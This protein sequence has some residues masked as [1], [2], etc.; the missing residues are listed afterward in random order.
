M[1][2]R[3][4]WLLLL[5]WALWGCDEATRSVVKAQWPAHTRTAQAQAGAMRATL[6]GA[7]TD[8]RWEDA[9]VLLQA[10]LSLEDPDAQAQRHLLPHITQHRDIRRRLERAGSIAALRLWPL[11]DAEVA[12]LRAMPLTDAERA[13]LDALPSASP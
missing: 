6:Q 1:S 7:L 9:E 10:L 11:L 12:A 2:Q 13:I 3:A 4:A 8:E 5:L